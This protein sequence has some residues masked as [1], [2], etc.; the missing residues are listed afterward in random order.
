[1]VVVVGGAAGGVVV[2]VVVVTAVV[3]GV[4][5]HGTSTLQLQQTV[6]DVG[7]SVSPTRQLPASPPHAG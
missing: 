2:V 1:L 6:H 4:Q 5:E 3:M 7:A